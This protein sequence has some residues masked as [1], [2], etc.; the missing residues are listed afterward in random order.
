MWEELCVRVGLTAHAFA[1]LFYVYPLRSDL[2]LD[3]AAYSKKKQ[4]LDELETHRV[5]TDISVLEETF[6]L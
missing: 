3:G 1:E 4:P 2:N 6:W 5:A